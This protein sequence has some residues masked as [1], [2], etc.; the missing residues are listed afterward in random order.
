MGDPE[1]MKV[2]ESMMWTTQVPVLLSRTDINELQKR[3]EAISN[4]A[5]LDVDWPQSRA[6]SSRRT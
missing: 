5:M 6:V 2:L 3:S 4:L 1:A